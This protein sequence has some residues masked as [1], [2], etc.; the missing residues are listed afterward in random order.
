MWR[1]YSAGPEDL[2]A[3][4]EFGPELFWQVPLI[5]LLVFIVSSAGSIVVERYLPSRNDRARQAREAGIETLNAVHRL[6]DEFHIRSFSPD[7]ASSE[8]DLVKLAS[9]SAGVEIAVAK[10]GDD[11]FRSACRE[12]ITLGRRWAIGDETV[13]QEAAMTRFR[14]ALDKGTTFMRANR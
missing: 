5:A 13:T 4:L 3:Q 10:T 6:H 9:L 8:D 14:A 7:E 11:A 2:I 12:Y 1:T